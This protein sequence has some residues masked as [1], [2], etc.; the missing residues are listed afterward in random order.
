MA[1]PE[2]SRG[3]AALVGVAALDDLPDEQHR[4]R[5]VGPG[6]QQDQHDADPA[7]EHARAARSAPGWRWP[8]RPAPR[9][10]GRAAGTSAAGASTA[11]PAAGRCRTIATMT[12]MVTG[13]RGSPR[14][15]RRQ[16]GRLCTS[17]RPRARR[18]R[19]W[20]PA[21]TRPGYGP[22]R[23][24]A[25]GAAGIRGAAAADL[26]TSAFRRRTGRPGMGAVPLGRDSGPGWAQLCGRA[27]RLAGPGR[28]L[29]LHLPIVDL[30]RPCLGVRYRSITHGPALTAR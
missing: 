24:A 4:G 17:P 14:V 1:A 10:P 18:A 13:Q 7:H 27:S 30:L 21:R 16:A 25:G 6:D 22:G 19:P 12:L 26:V 8:G 29:W 20:S 3:P 15:L 9:P 2:A 5:R 23:G 28:R 11:G